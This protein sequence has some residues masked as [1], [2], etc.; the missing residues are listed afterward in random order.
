MM[1]FPDDMLGTEMRAYEQ[2]LLSYDLR[3]SIALHSSH[4][5]RRK[6][7]RHRAIAQRMGVTRLR[8]A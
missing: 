5:Y 8:D 2:G 1:C 3:E 6:P 4:G 7:G